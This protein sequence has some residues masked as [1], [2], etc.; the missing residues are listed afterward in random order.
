MPRNY[1]KDVEI[2]KQIQMC[3]GIVIDGHI[4]RDFGSELVD[5]NGTIYTLVS[6]ITTNCGIA[7]SDYIVVHWEQQ[8]GSRAKNPLFWEW[9][10]DEL[11]NKRTIHFIEVKR[12]DGKSWN[13][14]QKTY[15]IPPDPFIRAAIEC[16]TSTCAPRYIVAED[17]YFYDAVSKGGTSD[18]QKKIREDRTGPICKY[19]ETTCHVTVGT[20]KHCKDYFE[21]NHGACQSIPLS[22]NMTCPRVC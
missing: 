9:Y 6:W 15:R 13:S 18:N 16:A 4:I 5:R 14:F 20:P 22:G 7:I 8:C 2:A 17:M 12:F 3:D 11:H 1:F 21:I 19:L 10:F